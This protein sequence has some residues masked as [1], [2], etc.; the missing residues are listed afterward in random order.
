VPPLLLLVVVLCVVLV[1]ELLVVGF[2]LLVVGAAALPPP[3][4]PLVVSL[5]LEPQP[6][7]TAAPSASAAI[8]AT[9]RY[10]NTDQ[11]WRSIYSSGGA[12]STAARASVSN[13]IRGPSFVSSNRWARSRRGAVARNRRL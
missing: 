1:V 4:P 9:A 2:E 11:L 7:A 3:L 6:T 10:E 12:R 5:E 13:G 8:N